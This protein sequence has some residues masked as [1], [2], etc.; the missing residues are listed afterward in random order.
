MFLLPFG[1]NHKSYLV[2]PEDDQT[3]QKELKK[4][5]EDLKESKKIVD[6]IH[7]ESLKEI[8]KSE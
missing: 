4:W 8:G 3:A 6:E 1:R 7:Q 5:V 2:D